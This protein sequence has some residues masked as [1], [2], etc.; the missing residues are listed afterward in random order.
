M[1]I[2]KID[3]Q[4]HTVNTKDIGPP[5]VL[6]FVAIDRLRIDERYQRAIERRGWQN[7]EKIAD[8]FDWAK[9]SPLIVSRRS[10]GTFAIIDG[11]HRAHAAA[12]CA[13][14]QVPAL[15]SELTPQQEASAF[16]W[17]NGS[18]TALTP[19]QIFKAALAAFEPWAVQS[20]AV[21]K[22][23]GCRL[24]PYNSS[25]HDKEPGQVYCIGAVRSFVDSGHGPY[26]AAVLKGVSQ[27]VVSDEIRYYN[28][29]GINA[30]TPAA[31]EAGITN[32]DI[33]ADF[34]ARHDLADTERRTRQIMEQPNYKGESFKR[35]FVKSVTVLM[36]NF[37]Q[38]PT[39]Q[40]PQQ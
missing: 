27:S 38:H 1:A 2:R 16:S 34:L 37:A 9:F 15:I 7:I 3:I 17:I 11:Q 6:D 36:K 26:L 22:S 29:H 21:V 19:N 23:A 14:Q 18:V 4:D 30:L 8:N 12:L 32:P 13:V 39:E 28:T 35:L 20:D 31:I 40:G 10:D 25:A 5:P 33:I 24:M